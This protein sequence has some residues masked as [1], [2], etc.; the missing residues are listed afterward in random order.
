M[1]HS[2]NAK[3]RKVSQHLSL[4]FHKINDIHVLCIF[5][6]LVSQVYYTSHGFPTKSEKGIVW[7]T[8]LL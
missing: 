7:A 8:A 3:L 6:S 5:T 2:E 1:A 4:G